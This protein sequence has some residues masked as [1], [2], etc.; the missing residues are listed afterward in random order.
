[1]SIIKQETNS[2][3]SVCKFNTNKKSE[4][5]GNFEPVSFSY[6]IQCSNL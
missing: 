3:S 5:M 6:L 2:K 1:M 4:T